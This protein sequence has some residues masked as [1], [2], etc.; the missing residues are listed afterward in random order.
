MTVAII[1]DLIALS[2]LFPNGFTVIKKDSILNQYSNTNKPYIVSCKTIIK[3][4]PLCMSV[5]HTKIPKQCIIGGWYNR[6]DCT[7]YI[8]LNRAYKYKKQAIKTAKRYNQLY[9]YSLNKMGC[10]KVD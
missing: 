4:K 3:I 1:K 9:I 6:D 5:L 8:E 10:V 2:K 7:Y